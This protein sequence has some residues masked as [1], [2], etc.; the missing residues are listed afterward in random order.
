MI[1]EEPGN[2][3]AE[4]LGAKS[5]HGKS[6]ASLANQIA[7]TLQPFCREMIEGPMP[8]YAVDKPAYEIGASLMSCAFSLIAYGVEP[9]TETE[10]GQ[11]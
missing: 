7:K 1:A 10:K 4:E 6:R 9:N 2:G 11:S 8:I 5:R 3:A